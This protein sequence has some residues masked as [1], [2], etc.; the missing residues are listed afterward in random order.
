M[1]FSRMLKTIDTHTLGQPTR[2]VIGGAPRLKGRTMSEKM[3]CLRENADWVRTVLMHE[4]RGSG[5]MSGALIT[6]PCR[7]DADIGVIYFEVG[8]Y[9]PMC[10]HDTIGACTA[11]LEAGMIEAT[12]PETRIAFD[13][14]AGLIRV[15]AEVCD[16]T[17]ESVRFNNVPSFLYR[18]DVTVDVPGTGRVTCDLAYGGNFYAILPASAVCLEILPENAGRL[19]AAG[20]RIR[21]TI[22]ATVPVCHPEMPFINRITYVQFTGPPRTPGADGQNCVVIEPASLDR[23]PCGTGT[24][25][26][27]AAL[28]ARGELALGQ[29]FVYE[30][31][32]C[33][34]FVARAVETTRVGNLP[35]IVPEIK[36]QAFVT[37]LHTFVVS[38][39]DPVPNGF[40]LA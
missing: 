32:I 37:G 5:V 23:S 29:E 36:G 14:P 20:N 11:L 15:V 26:R 7:P 38:P 4:P 31:I 17:V 3:T 16:G 27:V 6:E 10:G 8:G 22:N 24:S 12:E 28:Y 30:S 39:N 9:V 40:V 34:R 1:R 13:T 35:A 18:A 21:D 2:T 19:I 25:A 33:T